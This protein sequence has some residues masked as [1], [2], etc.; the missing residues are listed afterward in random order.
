MTQGEQ[1]RALARNI[2]DDL[3]AYRQLGDLL[4]AQFQAALSGAPAQLQAAADRVLAQGEHLEA[5]RCRREALVRALMPQGE[6]L[7]V[8]KVLSGLPAP[9]GPRCRQAWHALADAVEAC[10]ARNLRNGEF[11]MRQ[12]EAVGRVL[13]GESDVY[14]AG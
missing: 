4:D 10:R 8:D 7:S 12:Q 1:L 3:A 11:F 5:S 9:A 14:Q 2:V 6:S 13:Y